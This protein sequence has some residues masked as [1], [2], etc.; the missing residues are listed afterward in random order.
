MSQRPVCVLAF[1]GGLDTSLVAIWLRDELG[2]DVVTATIDTGGFDPAEVDRIAARSREC[3]AIAHHHIDA[4]G[5]LFDRWIRYIIAAN[6]QKG[7]VYPLC[8]GVERVVQA[9][10][11]VDIARQH[12]AAAVS[13]GSTGAGNDQIRF[14]VVLRTLGPDLAIHAPIRDLGWGRAQEADYLAERGV[15]V[16]A[17]TRRYS[18][19]AGL[20]GTTIGGGETR[21]TEEIVPDSVFPATRS[22]NDA[23]AEAQTLVLRFEGGVPV[24]LDGEALEPIA[25][26]RR[27][28]AIAATHG[29][30]RGIHLGDTILGIKGRIAFEAPAATVVMHAHRELEKLVLTK[31]QQFVKDQVAD[32]YGLF[33]HEGKYLDPAMRD[34][35]ALLDSS[36]KRVTGEVHVRLHRGTCQA[37][38]AASPHSLLNAN[39]AAYGEESSLWSGR[40]AEGF[41]KISAIQSVL[42]HAARGDAE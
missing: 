39:K 23:P 8:V 19:N 38:A 31:W 15:F 3:G 5:E 16:D 35:E 27:L 11:M 4:T 21:R 6:Y 25:L 41:A 33:L 22:P 2:Y 36:Q 37:V 32:F 1:S 7:G 17:S 24:A 26:L 12:G 10:K 18:I 40:D 29:V 14:D 9:Q 13:H 20:W 28:D 30:G 34:I 42:A